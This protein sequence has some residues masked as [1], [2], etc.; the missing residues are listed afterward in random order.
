M[1]K[2]I[3]N[4]ADLFHSVKSGE[5][6]TGSALDVLISVRSRV[7]LG[8]KILTHPLCG[9]LR[10]NHQPFRSVIID[11]INGLVDLE[12]LSLIEQAVNIYNSCVS[13]KLSELEE[14]ARRD[15]AYLDSELMRASLEQYGLIKNKDLCAAPLLL[16][17]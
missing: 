6:I 8:A 14:N 17:L 9:N 1:F 5:L 7:H 10:P 4:N 3:T 11:E 2:L 13:I 15:Y 12:S 16:K